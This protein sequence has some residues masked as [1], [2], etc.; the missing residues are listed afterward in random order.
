MELPKPKGP[1]EQNG[2]WT[3]EP[4]TVEVFAQ[5]GR[6]HCMLLARDT[7]QETADWYTKETF[8]VTTEEEAWHEFPVTR[9]WLA[10]SESSLVHRWHRSVTVRT[11]G[12]QKAARQSLPPWPGRR[13]EHTPGHCS[14]SDRATLQTHTRS[15]HS[16]HISLSIV[17]TDCTLSFS[18]LVMWDVKLPA[19]LSQNIHAMTRSIQNAK[20]WH[21]TTVN[22][23]SCKN[24]IC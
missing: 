23:E 6:G 21:Y 18:C 13:L 14:W 9:R 4:P 2:N 22:W 12:A 19:K 16:E 15:H 24:A 7:W 8:P 17:T 3:K 5:L 20:T 10:L 1:Q 11:A